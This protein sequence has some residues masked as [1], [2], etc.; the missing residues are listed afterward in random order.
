[1]SKKIIR[2]IYG[3][4]FLWAS[5]VLLELSF[6][7]LSEGSSKGGYCLLAWGRPSMYVPFF[8]LSSLYFYSQFHKEV[9]LPIR[10]KPSTLT[11]RFISF[12]VDAVIIY[13][14]VVPITITIVL[15]IESKRTGSFAWSIFR[16]EFYNIDFLPILFYTLALSTLFALPVWK[17]KRS[18]GNTVTNIYITSDNEL[19]FVKSVLR[20]FLGAITI[21]FFMITV[22]LAFFRK[23]KRMWHDIVF[24]TYSSVLQEGDTAV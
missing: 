16:K 13:E 2:I 3:I 18:I 21:G 6:G 14:I 7:F 17:Q 15:F 11:R 19:S 5:Y 8:V 20:F 24:G 23:D 1:M 4:A 9:T 22:P 12:I 10:E